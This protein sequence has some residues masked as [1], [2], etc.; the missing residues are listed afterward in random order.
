MEC[1]NADNLRAAR[2]YSNSLRDIEAAT[3]VKDYI[4]I[5]EQL[6]SMNPFRGSDEL[7][8]RCNEE[9]YF[10]CVVMIDGSLTDPEIMDI[11]MM[12]RSIPEYKDSAELADYLES[13]ALDYYCK[14]KDAVRNDD[15][16]RAKQ[17][18]G[19]IKGF[20]DAD[21]LIEC[22]EKVIRQNKN[23][24]TKEYEK[25]MLF[26]GVKLEPP[27]TVVDLSKQ[28]KKPAFPVQ[29]ITTPYAPTQTPQAQPAAAMIAEEPRRS[30]VKSKVIKYLVLGVLMIV[31]IVIIG[32]IVAHER[33]KNFRDGYFE[34]IDYA[35]VGQLIDASI[36]NPK[37]YTSSWV[38]DFVDDPDPEDHQPALAV[39][40]TVK[41]NGIE[42]FKVH[43][44]IGKYG[45]DEGLY[46]IYNLSTLNDKEMTLSDAQWVS[47]ILE[48]NYMKK[49][50]GK[51]SAQQG[52]INES[53]APAVPYLDY[54]DITKISATPVRE[55]LNH[56]LN[57]YSEKSRSYEI[58]YIGKNGTFNILLYK[59]WYGEQDLDEP[60]NA[61]WCPIEMVIPG[62]SSYTLEELRSEFG[63]KVKAI[64]YNDDDAG[65]MVTIEGKIDILPQNSGTSDFTDNVDL[66]EPFR[67][68]YIPFNN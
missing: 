9:I 8:N 33:T 45:N 1:N 56:S 64:Y 32:K 65:Y 59:S 54:T 57:G 16:E 44:L 50:V 4:K 68:C 67:S 35:T 29:S 18:L 62:K 42:S 53:K 6:L 17:L 7:I 26:A 41:A 28:E 58:T 51:S 30:S 5:K 25:L 55:L 11:I 43:L 39:D 48:M 24:G 31:C 61:M 66:D 27:A 63:N 37:Y 15:F 60:P 20:V 21:E 10:R 34:G 47:D 40:G 49:G 13:G 22:C 52:G 12:L 2:A 3:N 14:A 38:P 19:Y 36:D 23:K 46:I